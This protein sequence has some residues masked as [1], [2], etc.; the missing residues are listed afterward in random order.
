MLVLKFMAKLV[1]I[2][3]SGASPNQIAAGFVLGMIIGLTPLWSLHNLLIVLLL[4]VFNVNLATAI[5][6]FVLFSGFAYLLDPLFHNFGYYLLVEVAPLRPLWTA[7]YNIPVIALG[8]FNNTV[9]MGSLITAIILL[10]PVFL[11]VRTFVN[12]YREKLD[13]KLQ[14]L[15]IVQ[16]LKGSKLYGWY[17][18]I[19]GMGE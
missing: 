19:K 2:L 13:P 14:K 6:S 11:A 3:R 7:L 17:E 9:V 18:R 1:K 15:K 10:V 5:F 12:I 8:R 4:I 16:L